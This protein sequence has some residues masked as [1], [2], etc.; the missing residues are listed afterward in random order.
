MATAEFV[1]SNAVAAFNADNGAS[2]TELALVSSSN[3]HWE[4]GEYD[5]I[6]FPAGNPVYLG[7][8]GEGNLQDLLMEPVANFF[9]GMR[10]RFE[11]T[12]IDVGALADIGWSVIS[13]QLSPLQQWR[14]THFDI[15]TNTGD[16]ANDFDFDK[17]GLVNL[18]EYGLGT[19]PVT[20]DSGVIVGSLSAG[21]FQIEFPFA[22]GSSDIRIAV[23]ESP[24][25][26]FDSWT[27]IAVADSDGIFQTVSLGA[28]AETGGSNA[29]VRNAGAIGKGF[30]RIKVVEQ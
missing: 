10:D 15:T 13:A 24:H 8:V 7:T 11:V 5:S 29:V 26:T 19:I 6:I 12:N 4:D 21:R 30:L 20:P 14:M 3:N 27:E 2:E 1:G 25:L 22:G 9:V 23:E 16:A 17:D 18:L 28:E